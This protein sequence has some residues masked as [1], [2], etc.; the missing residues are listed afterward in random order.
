MN[1]IRNVALTATDLRHN[2]RTQ[3]FSNLDLSATYSWKT[4]SEGKLE[5]RIT[6]AVK[7][8]INR[9]ALYAGGYFTDALRYMLLTN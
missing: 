8:A 6:L 1:S 7:N 4:G 3:N 5:H 2:L 9:T